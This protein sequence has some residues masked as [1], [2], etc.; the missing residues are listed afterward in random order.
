MEAYA[1]LSGL[2]G[3][4]AIAVF[5]LAIRKSYAIERATGRRKQG[6]LPSYTNVIATAAGW[7]VSPSDQ[8]T[9][10]LVKQLRVLLIV[11]FGLLVKIG[12]IAFAVG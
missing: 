11:V 2:F 6:D 3:L 10:M 12:V 5:V 1:A 4:L 9:W 8:A 7:G